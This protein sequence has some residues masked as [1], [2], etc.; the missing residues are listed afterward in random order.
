MS[1]ERGSGPVDMDAVELAAWLS[2]QPTGALCVST[3]GRLRAV[4]AVVRQAAGGSIRL[5]L[6]T[7]EIVD[8]GED[9]CLVADEFESYEGIRGVIVQGSATRNEQV[10]E[11]AVERVS[12]FSFARPVGDTPAAPTD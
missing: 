2:R 9:C 7:P 3:A 11:L 10:V 5:A 1:R 8:D 4:P 6:T 12:S